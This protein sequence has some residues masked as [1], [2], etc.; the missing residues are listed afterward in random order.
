MSSEEKQIF[1][2][3]STSYYWSSLF[4]PEGVRDD[5][6]KFYSFVRITDNLVDTLPQDKTRFFQLK[7]AILIAMKSGK[8]PSKRSQHLVRLAVQNMYYIY[9]KYDIDKKWIEAFLEAMELDLSKKQYN[10][11]R[12]LKAYMYGSAE[13]VGL[14]MSKIIGV[15]PAG[16]ETAKLQ[17]RAMRYINFI[18]DIY[19]DELLGR[20]YLP[21]SELRKYGLPGLTYSDAIKH[22]AAFKEF[23]E[24]QLK[25]Y[26]SWQK[27]ARAGFKY[28]PRSQ[29]IAVRTAVDMYSWTA[30]T[31][32]KDP[33]IVFDKRVKPSKAR[34]VVRAIVRSIHA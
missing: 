17:G 21:K 14:I 20:A 27:E 15:D 4:F 22:P 25:Y 31:I 8:L 13:V 10:N 1:K 19:E 33:F 26:N 12:E 3:G 7:N 34:V 5:V 18:R 32:A 23:V 11:M 6:F 2:A 29:R 28:I 16:Y 9:K 30:K 24:A